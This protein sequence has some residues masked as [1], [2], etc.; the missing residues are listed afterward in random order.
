[1]TDV[2]DHPEF[3]SRK[4]TKTVD[5][6]AIT[7]WFTEDFT[8]AELKTL[9]AKERIPQT[10]PGNARFDGKFEVPTLEEVLILVQ[11]LNSDRARRAK[12]EKRPYRPV[13]VYPETKHP[14]YFAGIGLALEAPLVK[15]LHRFGYHGKKAPVF[16][17]SFEVGSLK[18]LARMTD[19]PLIQLLDATGKPF[20]FT[21]SGDPRS[22]ADL[23]T[24]SGLTEIARYA[25]GIGVNK[26]LMITRTPEGSLAAPAALV[27]DA[28]AAGLVVHGWA[29]RAQSTFPPVEFRSGSD[30]AAPG[31][32]AGE[33]K[34]FLELGMDGFFIDQP[35]IGVKA[36][37]LR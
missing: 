20:D 32:L 1:T 5:G 2:A 28:H 36:L 18:R 3:A 10:R 7:G 34:R 21:A 14:S 17:Q 33:V 35:D 29:F 19:L 24:P 13:G 30:P 6:T 25:D 9:R 31:D 15:S 12:A 27:A 26:N 11:S 37:T 4:A 22:Y 8:L 23:A 16:L